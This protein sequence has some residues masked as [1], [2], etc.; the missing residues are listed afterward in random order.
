MAN[1]RSNGGNGSPESVSS[2]VDIIQTPAANTFLVSQR[3]AFEA[4]KFWARRMRAYADQMEE[5]ASC[6]SPDEVAG[7]QTRFLERLREDYAVESEA[8][9]QLLS[10]AA[11]PNRE[12]GRSADA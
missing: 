11:G 12:S 3:F 9:G 6:R 7:A 4:A 1:R 5:L 10:S 8:L 2:L